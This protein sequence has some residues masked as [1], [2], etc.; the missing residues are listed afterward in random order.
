M[1]RILSLLISAILLLSM[2]VEVFATSDYER[3]LLSALS[4]MQG[5]TNGSMRYGDKVSRAECAKIVVQTSLHRDTV[6][7]ATKI[8]PFKDVTYTHWASPYIAVG[9][10][11]GLFKGY[12]DATFKPSNTVLYE[13]AITMFLRV[14]G[15][16]DE[17]FKNDWPYDRIE[18]AKS[19]GLLNNVNR[20]IGQELT[21]RDISA[22]AYNTLMSY[23][24]N[25]QTTYLSNFNRTTGPKTVSSSN[26]YEDFGADNTLT[27]VR[28]GVKTSLSEVRTNDVAY[29]MEEYNTALV[30]S[31]KITGIYE[32]ATPNKEAPK[33][34]TIS[35]ITYNIEGIDAYSKLSAGGSFK[36]GDTVTLLL[37][38]NGDIADVL[39][40]QQLSEKVY[41]FL[42]AS[43]TKET[44]VS[45]TSVTKPYVKLVLPSGEAREYI[46]SKDYSSMLNKVVIASFKD[47]IATLSQ[48]SSSGVFGKF[49]W[50]QSTKK[51]GATPLADD[52]KILE[53][54]TIESYE[55]ATTAT[56]FPQRLNGI[57]L[58]STDILYVSKNA[59]GKVCEL[60]LNDTT[61]DMHTYGIMTKAKSISNQMSLSGSYEYISG[62]NSY[63]L[64]TNN[65]SF[66]VSS[67][68]AVKI[69]SGGR[70]V[71]SISAI[72][73]VSAN[74]I[75]EISGSAITVGEKV[76]TMADNVQ[77]YIKKSFE[78]T[79]ITLDELKECFN[80]YSSGVYVDSNVTAGGRVRIIVLS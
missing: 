50:T 57:T 80:N 74:K 34:V 40:N 1:K 26:W 36:Y 29:Y 25:S 33:S 60:I 61:G 31:K 27:V 67:G 48:S 38:K 23:S 72:P 71:S 56:V 10:K 49:T 76:Y 78:Y 32:S 19:I 42:T 16:T 22:M 7:L 5:D 58:G 46:A 39:T 17:D 15:Y 54:S 24:K 55:T 64:N 11:N 62:G 73:K 12:L 9:I 51:L 59:D 21:R 66:S 14:L 8:S 41:G 28:D 65:Q 79:M 6:S 30:Y 37:G 4:I 18:T 68:Q 47:G 45:G 69:V 75:T 52:V 43:G 63:S 53:V 35:G 13:E 2:I 3:E 20:S 44:T 70:G 77:I